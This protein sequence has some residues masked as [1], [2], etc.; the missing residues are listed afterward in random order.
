[1][2]N[3]FLLG[4]L[5]DDSRLLDFRTVMPGVSNTLPAGHMWPTRSI[6]VAR[7]HLKN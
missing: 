6:F 1:M 4:G 3:P 2:S 5:N 7:K